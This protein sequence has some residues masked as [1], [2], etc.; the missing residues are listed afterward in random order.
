MSS[1]VVLRKRKHSQ[2]ED[3]L[4]LHLSSSPSP[5]YDPYSESEYDTSK[6]GPS[7]PASTLAQKDT[8]AKKRYKCSYEGCRK[9]YSKPSRLAEHERSHTGDR[10]FVCQACDKSYLRESHLQA[11]SR[12]H[13]P[14]SSRPFECTEDQCGKRFWTAQHLRVHSELHKGEKPFKCPEP[15]CEAA[16]AKHHQLREHICTKHAPPEASNAQQ[17]TR[18]K[19]IYVRTPWLLIHRADHTQIL[20]HMDLS[21]AAHEDRPS[22]DMSASIRDIEAGLREGN[23]DESDTGADD[24]DE[25]PQKKRRGGEVGRD[26]VCE[27]EG[28]SKDF[29]SKKAL[30]NHVNVN[31]LGRRDFVCH[32]ADC[33]RAFGYKHLL[34]RHLAKLHVPESYVD[35]SSE[36]SDSEDEGVAVQRKAAAFSIDDITGVSYTTQANAQVSQAEKLQCPHP[37]LA[38]FIEQDAAS[39][40][41]TSTRCQYVFSRAYDLRRH[42]KSEHGLDVHKERVDVWVRQAKRASRLRDATDS[43]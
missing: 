6:S 42:L 33:K 35:E 34:Q 15:D 22:S 23:P 16:Y 4:V 8:P 17:D 36:G 39:I 18:W 32:H 37:D 38:A 10:P 26:F 1:T 9:A 21:S 43:S 40:P 25:P 19:T 30:T 27:V 20:P 11:H 2:V 28:C 13:L 12:S 5:S 14:S 24:E 29:K 31:H 41:G 3:P 7:I